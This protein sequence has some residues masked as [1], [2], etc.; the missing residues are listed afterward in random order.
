MIVCPPPVLL[1]SPFHL[2]VRFCKKEF[3][4]SFAS[5]PEYPDQIWFREFY[6]GTSL[7]ILYFTILVSFCLSFKKVLFFYNLRGRGEG[8]GWHIQKKNLLFFK[9]LAI[10]LIFEKLKALDKKKGQCYAYYL[11]ANWR[12]CSTHFKFQNLNFLCSFQYSPSS[13]PP[14]SWN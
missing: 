4:K 5:C 6:L 10:F 12:S 7:W 3:A 8:L 1:S 11:D 13:L 9:L 2:Y 14:R